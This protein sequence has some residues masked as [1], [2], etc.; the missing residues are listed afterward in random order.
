MHTNTKVDS[1]NTDL[2]E[3][4]KVTTNWNKARIK[5]IVLLVQAM[6][7][8][9]SVSYAKLAQ[10]FDSTANYESNLRRIQRFFAKFHFEPILFSK[11]IFMLLPDN[12]PY[13]LSMD[14]TNWKFGNTDINILMI[15]VC[16]KGVG[17]PLI[18]R[19]LPKRG[20][21]NATE[22]MDLIECYIKH[23]GINSIKAFMA[24]RE[25]IGEQWFEDLISFKISFYIRLRNNM[26]VKQK[27]QEPKKVFWL[28][29]N[30]KHGSYRHC[31][32]LYYLG[33]NLI[34]LSGCKTLN[35]ATGKVDYVIIASYNKQDQAMVFY[36]D[37]WQ[38]ESMFK[39]MK[40]SGFNLE[41]THLTDLERLSKLIAVV[42]IAFI[43][44][45]LAGI[46]KHENIKPIKT[47]KHGRKAY[48]LFKYGLIR[49]A[50][51]LNN[52]LNNSDIDN[53]FKILSCT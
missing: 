33:K 9:Q 43:W 4:F 21:S 52:R 22:R 26:L 8:L 40:S 51:A 20:N 42:A 29:N 25:F 24:D 53:C 36:K 3:L 32:K 48:S 50:C 15:S 5:C 39:A 38:I 30:L 2:F 49:I 1:K 13:R 27:G 47:K 34:Y 10:G 44:A 16:Y 31:E 28:F 6:I 12:P 17:I 19:L 7:K 18:W 46:D 23:F 14:R 35:A 37:R 11:L 41:D 45:Y